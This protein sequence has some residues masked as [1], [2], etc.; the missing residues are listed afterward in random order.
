[1]SENECMVSLQGRRS[2][3]SVT[4]GITDSRETEESHIP[5]FEV[6]CSGSMKA[7]KL[8]MERVAPTNLPIL[9]MGESGTGKTFLAHRLHQLSAQRARPFLNVTCSSAASEV[10]DQSVDE[11]VENGRRGGTLFLKEISDLSA[12]FQKHLLHWILKRDANPQGHDHDVRLISSTTADMEEEM[13]ARRFRQDLYYRLKG[14]CLHVPPLRARK[15]DIPGLADALAHKHAKL[16][17][18][19]K[20]ELDADDLTLL[21]TCDWHGNIRELDNV[22]KQIVILSDAKIV[23]AELLQY[24]LKTEAQKPGRIG[25]ETR[26]TLKAAT[27]AASRQ[28]EEQL[29]LDALAKTRW[30]RKR[31]AQELQISY[32]SL[33]FKLKQI[34]GDKFGKS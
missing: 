8:T 2:L 14:V 21:Q 10:G 30:N 24:R 27:R 19:A 28:V 22:I 5:G 31:A 7:L 6:S 25:N 18:R 9:L 23:L 1:M 17:G 4:A 29:I 26:M 32:K 12:N 11:L 33:L 13:I 3:Q 16:Q 15:E 34:G 20:P